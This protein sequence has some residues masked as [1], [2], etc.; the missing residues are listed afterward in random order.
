MPQNTIALSD[1]VHGF[2]KVPHKLI[3]LLLQTREVQRLRQIKQL[4]MGFIV[5]P[6]AE[7]S[8]FPHALG[9]MGL[10]SEA[11]EN[12]EAKGTK[13]NKSEKLAALA[14]ILLH[15][16]GHSPFSHTL[17]RKLITDATHEE[18]SNALIHRLQTKLDEPLLNLALQMINKEYQRPF[19]GQLIS[20]QLDMDRLDYLR[21]DSL[22][23][24]VVEGKIGVDRIL[25]TLCVHPNRD[26][27]DSHLAIESKGV[28][29]VE[30]V[31][32]A[33][34]LMYWQVYLHKTVVAADAVLHGVIQRVR[35]LIDDGNLQA[36]VGISPTLHWFLSQE[37]TKESL[38]EDEVLDQF[39]NLDDADI[40]YSLKKWCTSND[41]I[42]A[43]LS[44][45]MMTRNLFRCT[46]I[47][48]KFN[49]DN[50]VV[51]LWKNLVTQS[52]NKQGISDSNVGRYYLHTGYSSNS[53]YES[54]EGDIK[55]VTPDGKIYNLHEYS[56]ATSIRALTNFVDKQYV[57]Y[58]KS[59][60][61]E[62]STIL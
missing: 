42:L 16:I 30:N 46:F 35:D 54:K 52:L 20:G 24:S 38:N 22:F 36:I 44:H 43:D 15:D 6:S 47:N 51:Q 40:I 11:L 33:R 59:V 5:F 34:R 45:R 1:P 10:L 14:A 57:C 50:G 19:F 60:D 27:E 8:R 31:L 3:Q 48:K 12:L 26:G 7:H 17:E 29:A 28:Y 56:D 21:R 32:I 39:L 9:S 18:I 2:I 58:P 55:V 61:L 25:R 37:I 4:G 41:Q 13:I 53:T 23:T 62:L 49:K